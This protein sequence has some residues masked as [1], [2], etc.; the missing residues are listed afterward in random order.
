MQTLCESIGTVL[1]DFV[2]F[3]CFFVGFFYVFFFSKQTFHEYHHN[4]EQFVS[5]SRLTFCN[6]YQQTKFSW[7]VKYGSYHMLR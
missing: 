1:S 4:V 2:N 7:R 5:R 6:G 3:A